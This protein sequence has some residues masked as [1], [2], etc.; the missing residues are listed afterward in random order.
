MP[1]FNGGGGVAG[2]TVESDPSALKLA[3]NLSDLVN[4]GTART[5]LQLSSFYAA[6]SHSHAITDVTNLQTSLNGKANTS[7][8]HAISDVTNL[9]TTLNGK[10]NTGHGHD[11]I[12][13]TGWNGIN[14][15]TNGY[16][17]GWNGT[18]LVWVAQSEGISDAPANGSKYARQNNAWAVVTDGSV[19][20]QGPAGVNGS[21]LFHY[22]GAYNNGVTYLVNDAVTFQGSTYVMANFVGGAGYD[23][24]GYPSYWTLVVSKGDTGA[25]GTNGTNGENGAVTSAQVIA[26]L[27][28]STTVG[29]GLAVYDNYGVKALTT[30]NYQSQGPLN[31]SGPY[32]TQN[33]SWVQLPITSAS[34]QSNASGYTNGQFD[35]QHYPLEL[36]LVVN[37]TTYYI[38]AR[39]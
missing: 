22:Q 39:S 19:G 26:D 2:I 9:Q 11:V 23:P 8:T 15:A 36:A 4:K 3:N 5:N 33:G 18:A 29:S 27:L 35:T 12:E 37:G 13:I 38:P 6:L 7:H 10:A 30:A 31:Y 34:S 16:V 17:L 28:T 20:P 32:A 14:G 25:A 21:M 1:I 24:V